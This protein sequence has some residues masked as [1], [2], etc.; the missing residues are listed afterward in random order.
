M[1]ASHAIAADFRRLIA[2]GDLKAGD[3]LPVESQ[4]VD[5]LGASKGVVREALRILETEGLLEVRRGLGGGPRVRHP[6]IS[7]AA[8]GMGVYLQLGDVA[9]LDVWVTRDR[10][11]GGAV[12]RLAVARSQPAFDALETCV[13]ALAA[14]IGD[15]DAY[16]LQMLD[17]EETAVR[18]AGNATE[19]V[20]VMALRHIIAAELDAATRA[21]VDVKEALDAERFVT[22]AWREAVRNIKAGHRKAARQ[23]YER[24]AALIRNGIADRHPRT[25]GDAVALRPV[26]PAR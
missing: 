13:S 5:T 6:S 25:V 17:I 7:E 10:I 19:H 22:D 3:P 15:F 4:L 11:I 12:E 8:Q 2:R 20:L 1:K 23:A 24:Q 16:Y 26:T 21:V 9:V 14:R 18:L